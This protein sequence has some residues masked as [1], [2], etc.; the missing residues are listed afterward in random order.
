MVR[1][2]R[3]KAD[4]RQRQQQQQQPADKKSRLN[5][6]LFGDDAAA[7]ADNDNDDG[8][9]S[10]TPSL[11]SPSAGW[12]KFKESNPDE[13]RTPLRGGGGGGG[14]VSPEDMGGSERR[15][16][17][18]RGGGDGRGFFIGRQQRGGGAGHFRRGQGRLL[19]GRHRENL[20]APF[21]DG[22]GSNVA[23]NSSNNGGESS[24]ANFDPSRP[25]D[26]RDV[27]PRTVET[28]IIPQMINQAR[29]LLCGGR[30]TEE[31]VLTRAN[32][33]RGVMTNTSFDFSNFALLYYYLL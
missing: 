3:R 32:S 6:E 22:G 17:R 19:P 13:F 28:I 23:N 8:S 30:I 5:I 26:I 11:V 25:N 12:A 29:D 9:S 24:V 15:Q 7:A 1:G 31:Q 33:Y 18:R 2:K 21:G 20:P 16:G 27:D 10:K 4:P 14:S